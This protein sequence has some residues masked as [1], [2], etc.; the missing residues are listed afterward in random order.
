MEHHPLLPARSP[1][2]DLPRAVALR[3]LEICRD[4]QGAS[5]EAVAFALQTT[6]FGLGAGRESVAAALVEAGLLEVAVAHLHQSSPV[7]WV[8]WRSGAG[9]GAGVIFSLAGNLAGV[10]LPGMNKVQLYVDSGMADAIA[11]LLKVKRAFFR[12]IAMLVVT[13]LWP[14]SGV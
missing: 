9:L 1:G 7:E 2:D 13:D 12:S 3:C 14:G 8:N 10:E 4:P 6:I 5:S 11:S